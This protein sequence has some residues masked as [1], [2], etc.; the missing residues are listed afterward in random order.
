MTKFCLGCAM[1]FAMFSGNAGAEAE[2]ETWIV[3]AGPSPHACNPYGG[4]T[5][6]YGDGAVRAF[7]TG[8]LGSIFIGGGVAWYMNPDRTG[9]TAVATGGLL[10]WQVALAGQIPLDEARRWMLSGGVSYG[11][12]FI[13][14]QGFL[15]VLALEYRL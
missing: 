5:R 11:L 14:Y 4:V 13:Q 9:L 2:A 7:V 6:E 1:L 8:G 10:G 3:N 12:F 15:P